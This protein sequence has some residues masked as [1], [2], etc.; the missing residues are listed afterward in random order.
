VDDRNGYVAEKSERNEAF[1]VVIETVVLEGISWTL[2]R[3][4]RISKVETV[5][6]QVRHTLASQRKRIYEVYIRFGRAS[7]AD[8]AHLTRKLSGR[9]QTLGAQ[10]AGVEHSISI[11]CAWHFIP[12]GPLQR[13]LGGIADKPQTV[14][15]PARPEKPTYELPNRE[16]AHRTPSNCRDNS[17][18]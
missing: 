6:P 3:S 14:A 10:P 5:N 11:S 18:R 1:F 8:S 13:R 7:N 16:E 17:H 12:Y 4:G 15:K 2:K 9:A